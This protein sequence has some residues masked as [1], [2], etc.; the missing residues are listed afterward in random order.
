MVNRGEFEDPRLVEIYDAE[1]VWGWDDD[2]FMALLAERDAPRVLDFGCGT[3]RLAIA[4]AAAGHEVT[5]VEPAR[6]ALDAAR[7]KP[8]A[9]QVRWIEGAAEVVPARAY[10]AVMMTGHV[11]QSLVSDEQ[12]LSTL[13]VLRRA[14]VPGGRL[15]FD[16]RD[17][18]ARPWSSWTPVGS[19]RPVVGPD[20]EIVDTWM[21]VDLVAEATV[22][23]TRH[24]AFTHSDELTSSA[25]LR[26]RSE[27]ELRTTVEAAGFDVDRVYGGWAREPVGTGEDG[28]LIAVA[29]A[30]P[31][32]R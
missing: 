22:T 29:M 6:A 27:S 17:P 3:G 32:G 31:Q 24:Y 2:L 15:I 21:D 23:V 1:T 28:E 19:R 14:L 4:M 20:G 9:G 30:R 12:W 10:E 18:D 7:R 5:A 13:R 16:S 26:F 8:G 11:A 25:T